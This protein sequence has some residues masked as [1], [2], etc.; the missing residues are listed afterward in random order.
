MLELHIF[1]IEHAC[2]CRWVVFSGIPGIH[3]VIIGVVREL[4][5]NAPYVDPVPV[6]RAILA[7]GDHGVCIGAPQ[8]R[9]LDGRRSC[10]LRP[11]LCAGGHSTANRRVAWGPCAVCANG[12]AGVCGRN[13]A[14]PWNSPVVLREGL[15]GPYGAMVLT[16][17]RAPRPHW[18]SSCAVGVLCM[19]IVPLWDQGPF[20]FSGRGPLCA[21]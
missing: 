16:A 8:Q 6:V 13:C 5:D 14:W 17:W 4:C 11:S 15:Q 9:A 20:L 1:G 21:R 2:F 3:G 19:H 18:G 7:E 12:L 10:T